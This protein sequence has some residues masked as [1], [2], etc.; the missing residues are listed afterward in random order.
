M[1]VITCAPQKHDS[2]II[3]YDRP[4]RTLDPHLRSE[5]VT[6]SILCNVYEC[7]VDYDPH[8]KLVPKLAENWTMLDSLTWEI[9]LRKGVKFH[10]QKPL[11]E[12]DVIYS[13]YRVFKLPGSE[14]KDLRMIVDTVTGSN[15]TILIKTRFP[16]Y[17]LMNHLTNLAIVP[18]NFS[19]FENKPTGS[20]PYRV[21][22]IYR[23]SI[24]CAVNQDYWDKA[25]KIK[26]GIFK[27]VPELSER[28]RLIKN[29]QADIAYGLPLEVI[30]SL[31][32]SLKILLAPSVVARQL[33]YNLNKFPF[34]I[35]Q[36]RQAL[37]LA[38]DRAGLVR[39]LY[40][41]NALPANQYI[42]MGF[43]GYA[44]DFPPLFYN[45][46]EA[47]KLIKNLIPKIS[48]KFAYAQSVEA[49]G[50]FI[51]KNLRD[52]GIGVYELALSSEEYW[53]GIEEG[54]LDCYLISYIN[55]SLDGFNSTIINSFHSHC[56]EKGMGLM[57]L[58]GYSNYMVDSL[59]NKV[60]KTP[61]PDTRLRYIREIQK[62]LLADL[63]SIPVVW[64]PRVYGVSRNIKWHPRLDQQIRLAEIEYK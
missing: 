24:V 60:I 55:T 8:L 17:Y 42:P 5:I 23:D 53:K 49:V 43:I 54:T 18:D 2:V 58:N 51:A 25:P 52:I 12:Q 19:D 4:P 63:P 26:K 41:N 64:E 34:N 13:L 39:E 59:I 37:N 62:Q 61:D 7:L 20:G 48:I 11:T 47:Q 10:N 38:I 31:G 27:F 3:L 1:S 14:M 45:P 29:N 9:A 36:F 56:P 16:Y 15:G 44:V 50:K 57:N 35:L 32:D 46:T 30:Q 22:N 21:L 33:E 6:L 40:K 28:I